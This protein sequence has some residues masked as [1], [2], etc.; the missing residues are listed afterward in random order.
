MF[1]AIDDGEGEGA[2]DVV[3]TAAFNAGAGADL[4][5]CADRPL[6]LPPLTVTG[7]N[8]QVR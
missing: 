4:A 1:Y 8:V 3:S 2:A 6:A 5:F 7:G